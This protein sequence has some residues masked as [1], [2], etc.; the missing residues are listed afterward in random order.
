MYIHTYIYIYIHIYVYMY[1]CICI[2]IYIF[3]YVYIYVYMYMYIYIHIYIC[4][5]IYTYLYTFTYIQLPTT[6]SICSNFHFVAAAL[7]APMM[8]LCSSFASA[9]FTYRNPSSLCVESL[10]SKMYTICRA[11]LIATSSGRLPQKHFTKKDA[12]SKLYR[13]S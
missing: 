10:N 5:Y 8:L 3:I 12:G 11:L 2:Y 1:I 9:T 6:K 13:V 7:S 4:I